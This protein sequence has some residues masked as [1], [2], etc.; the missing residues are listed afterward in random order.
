MPKFAKDHDENCV[1]FKIKICMLGRKWTTRKRYSELHAFYCHLLESHS[2]L[3]GFP[4]KTMI[5]MSDKSDL[6]LRRQELETFLQ[7]S[8]Y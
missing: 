6:E 2:S 5:P 7:V 3:P 8:G 1:Y 4:K